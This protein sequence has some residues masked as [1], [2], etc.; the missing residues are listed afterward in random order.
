MLN[1]DGKLSADRALLHEII[2]ERYVTGFCTFTPFDDARRLRGAKETDIAVAI[3]LN[4]G[5]VSQHPE[6]LLYP[7]EE[8]IANP[9]A[10][11]DPGL[12]APTEVNR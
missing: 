9:N 10:P 6:R 4:T 3:P 12:Y 2:E 1:A 7:Q 11:A 5:A 8:L